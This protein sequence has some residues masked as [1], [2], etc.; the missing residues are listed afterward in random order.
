M[1]TI[2]IPSDVPSPEED[3]NK[4]WKAFKGWG[5][6]EKA[7]IDVLAHRN[8]RQRRAISEAYRR[9][10]RESL[11]DRLRSELSGDFGKAVVLWA[12]DPPERDAKLANKAMKKKDERHVLML[13]EIACA[14]S[15]DHLM[16]VRKAYCFLFNS[17]LE[18]DVEDHFAK[19]ESLRRLL[20]GL[21]TSYR[22]NG[23]LVDEELAR[24]EAA[25]LHDAI[26]MKQPDNEEVVRILGTRSKSQ[27]KS[28]FN[29]YKEKYGTSI[30]E[31][32]ESSSSGDNKFIPVLKVAVRCIES[33]EKHFAE[34]VR[35]SIVGLGTD[36][37]ALTRAIVTRAE[38][39]M[40][41]IKEEYKR[42]KTSLNTDV[43]GDTSG[44]YQEFLLA[45][46]GWA[47]P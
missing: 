35:S 18:E 1:S 40:K 45:L 19:Q 24:S 13:I 16:A 8:A 3:C 32:L 30:D 26:S 7:V 41:S 6:D 20:M 22:Y 23:E 33:P 31:D 46:V 37:D 44:Y 38:V 42:Y 39:D 28:T 34:V 27:L 17:S 10:H 2:S 4:L 21:V 12:Q 15:P 43:I 36:E 47:I 29:C 11:L 5:T 25:T 9:L 14:S